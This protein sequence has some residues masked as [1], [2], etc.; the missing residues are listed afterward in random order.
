MSKEI[1]FGLEALAEV[2]KGV[3]LL[4]EA[5]KITFGPK[6]N[7]VIIY[8]DNFPKVTKDGVTVAR[9]ISSS[10]PLYDV[11]IQLVKEAA[12]KTADSAGDGTTTSTILAQSLINDILTGSLIM[13]APLR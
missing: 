9:S 3:D 2:K 5:V 7:T 10:N 8:E 1:K 13:R 4:A 12:S 11:G 6:G